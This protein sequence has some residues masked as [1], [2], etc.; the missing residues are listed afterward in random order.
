M[1]T[2]LATVDFKLDSDH[3]VFAGDLVSKGP[4][5]TAAVDIAMASQASCVRG[6]HEDRVL[7]A[8]RDLQIHHSLPPHPIDPSEVIRT[9]RPPDPG[10]PKKA[11]EAVTGIAVDE[12][13]DNESFLS[14]D[15]VDQVLAKS[16]SKEQIK[17]L[18]S[19]PVILD[20]GPIVGMG[21]V[22]VVHAGLVP[23]VSLHRQ[24]PISVMQMRT[25]D[26]ETHVPS[27]VNDGTPW[28]KVRVALVSTCV[29]SRSDSSVADAD[30]SSDMEQI[31][32]FL[33]EE[34]ALHHHLR[35]RLE[36]WSSAWQIHE[37]H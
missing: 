30:R 26:L 29:K 31:S 27:H 7:L 4:S 25:I 8:Y 5:S 3:L 36:A 23:G 14:G 10:N 2:L 12:F 34:R 1:Q 21:E 11:K 18:A 24:D 16:F 17:Y 37:G 19:C 33:T 35:S 6:N 22:R 15:H 13:T 28:T 20:V 32:I 9:G